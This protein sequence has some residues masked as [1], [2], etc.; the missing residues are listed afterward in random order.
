VARREPALAAALCSAGSLLGLVPHLMEDLVSGIPE[1]FGISHLVFEWSMGVAVASTVVAAVL[2]VRGRRRAL[3]A[4]AVIGVG[5]VLAAVLDHP[6]AFTPDAFREGLSSRLWVWIVTIGQGA[7][8][9]F[10]IA[11]LRRSGATRR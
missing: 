11:A 5:W 3:I 10:A 8:A 9:V 4:A 2:A 7:A 1:R 6:G